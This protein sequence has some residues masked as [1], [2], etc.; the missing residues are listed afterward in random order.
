MMHNMEWADEYQNLYGGL[1]PSKG[2]VFQAIMY[3]YHNQEKPI[4]RDE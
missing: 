3:I 2:E 4:I 1:F